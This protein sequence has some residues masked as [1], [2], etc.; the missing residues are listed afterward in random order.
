VI[1]PRVTSDQ[2]AVAK[3][4]LAGH[5]LTISGLRAGRASVTVTGQ[6]A[7]Q[8]KPGDR[9]P[10]TGTLR[11]TVV[12]NG[13]VADVYTRARTLLVFLLEET[14]LSMNRLLAIAVDS[15]AQGLEDRDRAAFQSDMI[16]TYNATPLDQAIRALD[17]SYRLFQRGTRT[18]AT[19]LRLAYESVGLGFNRAWDASLLRWGAEVG[20]VNALF[21]ARARELRGKYGSE[22]ERLTG[23]GLPLPGGREAQALEQLRARHKA[24]ELKVYTDTLAAYR[25]LEGAILSD[26]RQLG[27]EAWRWVELATAHRLAVS[28][29]ALE[30]L[31]YQE[32]AYDLRHLEN[33]L[34][35]KRLFPSGLD[36]SRLDNFMNVSGSPDRL[37]L[38]LQVLE[39][40]KDK[41]QTLHK[42]NDAF[43]R[44]PVDSWR[45]GR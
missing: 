10:F 22:A 2:P 23:G 34:L 14:K 32:F 25:Q 45:S 12:P 39:P 41:V 24:D 31:V 11:V 30:R 9:T 16:R 44:E 3:A 37:I 40:D 38:S 20:L 43:K 35:I 6:L 36:E 5:L 19:F 21:D 26:R 13:R 29:T 8:T 7:G 42:M 33:P 15:K 17:E 18:E 4:E 28:A 1:G 27:K